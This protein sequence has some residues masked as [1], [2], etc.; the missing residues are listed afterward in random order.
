[1]NDSAAG[2]RAPATHDTGDFAILD[3][4]HLPVAAP[5]LERV[6]RS[7]L[8]GAT[9]S[10]ASDRNSTCYRVSL[11]AGNGA[12][13]TAVIKVPRF[14]RQRTNDDVTFAGETAVLAKLPA[15]GIANAYRLLARVKAGGMHFLVTTNVPGA[16]P[17]PLLHSLDRRQLAALFDSLLLMDRQGLMHYDLK[18]GNI[19]FDRDAHGFV[20]F[21][22]ARFEPW[23]DAFTPAAAT[24]CEDY[25]VSPN[26]YFPSRSNV[27]NFEFRTLFRYLAELEEAGSVTAPETFFRGYLQE[28]SRYHTRMASHLAGLEPDSVEQMSAR[29]GVTGEEVRCRLA[30]AAAY[31]NT[32]A[33]LMH[34]ASPSVT[35]LERSLV[36]FRHDVFERQREQADTSRREAFERAG[37]ERDI[38][39]LPAEYMDAMSGTFERVWRSR[40]V[41]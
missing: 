26:P 1:M 12:S 2:P 21:E 27:A 7:I 36:G 5:E 8:A 40:P 22:F 34:E 17:D 39:R 9:T 10:F 38:G 11:S 14:G 33:A 3:T 15:A 6:I 20:D 24:Y 13:D 28:K 29:A 32:L 19:L 41:P 37:H 4:G 25:N 31:E 23:L 35:D 16:P 30:K 18:P